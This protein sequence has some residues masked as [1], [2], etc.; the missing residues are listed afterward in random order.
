MCQAI[1]VL[2]YLDELKLS[3]DSLISLHEKGTSWDFPI[4]IAFFY[5]VPKSGKRMSMLSICRD[6]GLADRHLWRPASYYG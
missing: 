3:F 2:G 5:F 6:K 1:R 4:L